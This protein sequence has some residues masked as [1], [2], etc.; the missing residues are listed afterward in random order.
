MVVSRDGRRLSYAGGAEHEARNARRPCV[1]MGVN[2]CQFL[3]DVDDRGGE[4]APPPSS[5]KSIMMQRSSPRPPAPF[6]AGR[7]SPTRRRCV[8]LLGWCSYHPTS[9]EQSFERS[10]FDT[11]F[12]AL[13]RGY[14]LSPDGSWIYLYEAAQ[15]QTHGGPHVGTVVNASGVALLALRRDVSAPTIQH[16]LLRTSMRLSKPEICA[17]QV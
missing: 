9:P 12:T 2:T 15:A 1:P 7:R 11:S 14:V 8:S 4:Q 10:S 6:L 5:C 13:A 16:R 17:G 3:G